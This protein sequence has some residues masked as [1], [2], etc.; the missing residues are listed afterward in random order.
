[1][2][3]V[4]KAHPPSHPGLWSSSTPLAK[5]LYYPLVTTSRTSKLPVRLKMEVRQESGNDNVSGAGRAQSVAK[6]RTLPGTTPR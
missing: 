2:P 1:M 4:V 5:K 3:A 6:V